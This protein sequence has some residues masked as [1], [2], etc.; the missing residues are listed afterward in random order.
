MTDS[1]T[2][3]SRL[4]EAQSEAA[5][6]N[7]EL[8]ALVGC[9]PSNV[10]A[11]RKGTVKRIHKDVLPKVASALGVSES[12]LQKGI[13]VKHAANVGVIDKDFDNKEFVEMP[14]YL[15]V[16]PLKEDKP[17]DCLPIANGE[18]VC[19]PRS[20]FATRDLDPD[21]CKRFRVHDESMAP[22]L[23]PGDIVIIDCRPRDLVSGKIYAL[24]FNNQLTFRYL[25]PSLSGD[26]YVKSE[27][28]E[29][30]EET[31]PAARKNILKIIGVVAERSGS[32]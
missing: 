11:W 16:P 13:G 27:N 15:I 10:T 17:F 28:P 1:S 3:A 26:V 29:Y 30:P 19:Y 7:S 14:E 25:I 20:W 5:L 24:A 4:I 2:L 12:W 8:A 22:L 6:T 23:R 31:I 21:Q 9:Q 18:T 32:L